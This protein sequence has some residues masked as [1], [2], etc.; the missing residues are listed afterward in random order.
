MCTGYELDDAA[1]QPSN[2]LD[3][4][5]HEA[6]ELLNYIFYSSITPTIQ[7]VS[8]KQYRNQILNKID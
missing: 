8:S 5:G 4:A 1:P 7:Q 2:L 3:V 6:V